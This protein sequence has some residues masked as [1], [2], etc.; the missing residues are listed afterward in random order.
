MTTLASPST[1][2]EP[3]TNAD[4]PEAV[5]PTLEA[6]QAKYGFVPNLIGALAH[7]PALLDAY[8]AVDAQFNATSLTPRERQLVL[9]TASV[10]NDCDYCTAA[11]STIAKGML[12]VDADIVAAVRAGTELADPKLDALVN[13]VREIVIQR[14]QVDP[15]ITAAFLAA[16]YTE[17]QLAEILVGVAQKTISNFF[18]HLSPLP[19]DNAFQAEA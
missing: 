11:H 9:L 10:A 19:L 6:V 13:L 17:V 18:N 1:R 4:A 2:F 3:I 15:A 5:R 16:G 7:S 14:G 8:L 12:K